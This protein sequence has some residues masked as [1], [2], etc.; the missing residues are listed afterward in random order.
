MAKWLLVTA[1]LVLGAC[2]GD[3]TEGLTG[4]ELVAEIGCF[5][6]HTETDTDLAPTLHG[7]WGNEVELEDGRT[8]TVDEAYVRSSITEPAADVVAGFEA[9]MPTF[10]LSESEVDRLVEYVRSLG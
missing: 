3:S 10:G 4:S 6:C 1:T 9:R 8:V 2:G 7:I 5:A